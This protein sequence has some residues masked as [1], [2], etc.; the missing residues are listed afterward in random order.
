MGMCGVLRGSM[1]T[2]AEDSVAETLRANAGLAKACHRVC[3]WYVN[4]YM[5]VCNIHTTK[6]D[7]QPRVLM[8]IYG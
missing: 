7:D 1:G 5:L 4:L 2:R 8:R 3:F 6:Q